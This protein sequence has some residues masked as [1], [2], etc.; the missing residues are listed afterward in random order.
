MIEIK[1][2]VKKK[3]TN[4][5]RGPAAGVTFTVF[6]FGKSFRMSLSCISTGN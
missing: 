1:N 4:P 5:G 6:A 2:E 3:R